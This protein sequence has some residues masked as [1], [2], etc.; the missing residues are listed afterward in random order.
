MRKNTRST[1]SE[2]S[3]RR[4]RREEGVKEGS[5]GIPV[6]P[7]GIGTSLEKETGPSGLGRNPA[8]FGV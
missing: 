7:H 3:L 4:R 6:P 1:R 2:K 8:G 5:V